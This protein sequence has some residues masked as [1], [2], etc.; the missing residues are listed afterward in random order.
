MITARFTRAI[1]F[2]VM[3]TLATSIAY[4]GDALSGIGSITTNNY[5]NRK[6]DY[7]Y[8]IPGRVLR[9]NDIEYPVLVLIP[10]LSERG[11]KYVGKIF[12][13][14]ADREGFVIVSPS[15]VWDKEN[16]P[17]HT[18]YQYPKAWSGDALVRILNSVEKEHGIKFSK[19]YLHGFSAGAQFALRFALLKPELCAAC[20]VHA[21]GGTVVPKKYCGVKFLV[22][23]GRDDVV[24]MPKVEAFYN[25]ANNQGIDVEYR[26][27]DGGH[28]LPV[29]QVDDSLE[30]FRNINNL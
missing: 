1:P 22:S 20:S 21:S 7:F 19:L 23:V 11:E 13:G 15:F 30:F 24:R 6:L 29:S 9:Y 3:I 2:C 4:A 26:I 16:W 8:Y 12:K 27:Y 18:S 14:F 17:S 5:A 10:G 25:A 28:T